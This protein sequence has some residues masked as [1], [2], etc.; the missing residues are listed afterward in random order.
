MF[1]EEHERDLEESLNA[2]LRNVPEHTI[3]DIQYRVAVSADEDNGIYCFSAMV[4]Y[5]DGN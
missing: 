4:V 2:F 1:D 5:N 3:Q